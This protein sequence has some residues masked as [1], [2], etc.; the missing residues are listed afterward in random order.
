MFQFSL[1]QLKT[2]CH[3]LG[4]ILLSNNTITS[5]INRPKNALSKRLDM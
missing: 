5:L 4:N 3:V 1:C 2:I